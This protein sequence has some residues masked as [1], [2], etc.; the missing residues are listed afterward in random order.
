MR[1][2]IR[3][4]IQPVSVHE[5]M[6]GSYLDYAMSVIVGRALPD[7]RDGLK[8]VHRRILYG[9]LELGL[10][11]GRPYKKSARIVGEVMGKY[12]PHG[13][14]PIYEAIA[15]MVQDFSLRYPLVDGQGNFGSI[16]G[17]PPAAMRYTEA[18][19]APITMEMLAD[20]EKETVDFMPNFDES[21]VEPVVLPSKVPNLL[22]N[23]SSGIAVGMATNIPPHN[24]SEVVD[25]L[26]LVLD[27]PEA[28]V[29]EI[30]EMLPGPDFPTGGFICGREGIIQAYKTGKGIITLRGKMEVETVKDRENIIVK[31]IPYEVNKA[32]LV[33]KI[34]GLVEEKKIGGIQEVRDESDKEGTR[35]V[36]EVRRGENVDI[37]MNQLYK[38][39]PLQITYGI[40]NLALVNQQ[41]KLLN[42][43]ELLH[44]FLEHRREIVVRRTRYD[45]RKAE[46]RH[47]IISGLIVALEHLDQVI[48]LIRASQ[49][50][51]EARNG[52]MSKFKLSLP[53]ADAVLGMPLARLTG[54][55]RE[56]ILQEKAEL[57]GKIREYREILTK[58]EKVKKI[59]RD[60]LTSLK[61][62]FGDN[63][64]TTIVEP[65][66][67]FD[68][69]DLIRPEDIVVTVSHQGYVKRVPLETYRRQ[70]RGGKGMVAAQTKEED[71]IKHL[72]IC[73]TVDTILFFTDVGNV[74]WLRGYL[75]PEASRNAKGK[76]I[77]NLLKLNEGE[78]I[79]AV[80]PVKEFDPQKFL[81]MVTKNGLV[82]KTPLTAYSRP[83]QGGIIGLTLRE[84]DRLIE[85]KIT[86]GMKDVFLGTKYGLSIRFTEK[87]VQPIGRT[88]MGVIGIRFK[89]SDDEVVGAEVVD[90][91][92]KERSLITVCS[93]GFGK[94]TRISLYRRQHRGGKGIIDIKGGQRNGWV[95]GI[96][97]VAETDELILGTQG[98]IIIRM[99]IKDIRLVG[100]NTYGV[101]L[102]NLESGDSITDLAL[103]PQG[104]GDDVQIA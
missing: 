86:D 43:R 18:R 72:F 91:E 63:R 6:R 64:R 26:V 80:I 90:P 30:M 75:I 98:G 57:E 41:P 82:K 3:E 102:I 32:S 66:Q 22:I 7:V 10:E 79:A 77:V 61:K 8:P 21:M 31:E 11:P 9:M 42:I 59:I 13:D 28:T 50:V 20:L 34:A 35:I 101:K 95:I 29:E 2:E 94:R 96:R 52:L 47:H 49:T 1:E 56:K 87:E 40:I 99:L 74:H 51:E 14:A 60:E 71:F 19:L 23:G 38:H 48:K 24:L 4:K 25:G 27:K 62:K 85:V 15:R 76:P 89:K 70:R 45:L 37:I 97:S 88:G 81:L 36:L 53:Q 44:L 84:N 93:K 103:V 17:D 58:P 65:I 67:E 16:D 54:L 12:H 100:R 83:R 92:E 46:E 55:E 73:S 69:I 33:E 104:N 5:E 78:K 39:T 68:D